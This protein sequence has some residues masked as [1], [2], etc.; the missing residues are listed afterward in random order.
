MYV[1]GG[2][3]NPATRALLVDL[4]I[5]SSYHPRIAA[6]DASEIL[7]TCS[8]AWLDYFH[9][10]GV[11]M[12]VI[13]KSSAFA[14]ACAHAVITVLPH[15]GSSI[16]ID[17]DRLPGPFFVETD[18]AEIPGDAA[19]EKIATEIYAWYQRHVAS[20]HLIEHIAEVFGLRVVP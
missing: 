19:R 3:E 17:G 1:L 13:L 6:A 4:G 9:R 2:D 18:R 20:E 8:F 7:R 5:E 16:L 14:S 11:E 15:H 10:P 12:A